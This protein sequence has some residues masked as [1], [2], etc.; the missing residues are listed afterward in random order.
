M[1]SLGL[2]VYSTEKGGE[3]QGKPESN[4]KGDCIKKGGAGT[5]FNP[6]DC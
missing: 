3:V 1:D 6:T 2:M 5:L 4:K